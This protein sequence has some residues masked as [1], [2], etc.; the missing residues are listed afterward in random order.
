MERI[1]FLKE[2]LEVRVA[3]VSRVVRTER[4]VRDGV[5]LL[6]HNSSGSQVNMLGYLMKA[7]A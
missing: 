3:V 2:D 5:L 6:L 4:S 7:A 1:V